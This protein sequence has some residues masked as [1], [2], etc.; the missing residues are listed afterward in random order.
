MSN[1][2]TDPAMHIIRNAIEQCSKF[3]TPTDW[4]QCYEYV[5]WQAYL[6]L[7]ERAVARGEEFPTWEEFKL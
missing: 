3:M 7:R 5:R 4:R 2:A 6:A 1:F